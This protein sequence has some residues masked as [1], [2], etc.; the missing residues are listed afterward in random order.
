MNMFISRFSKIVLS[1]CI[2]LTMF[3]VKDLKAENEV[4]VEEATEAVAS[5]KLT[6]AMPI[7]ENKESTKT[8]ID[9]ELEDN[10]ST[11]NMSLITNP[12]LQIENGNITISMEGENK[13]YSQNGA[14]NII[15][16]G[17]IT[18][19]GTRNSSTITIMSGTHDLTINNLYVT[20]DSRVSVID[21]KAGSNLNLNISGVNNLSNEYIASGVNKAIVNISGQTH[22]LAHGNLVIDGDGTLTMTSG[23]FCTAI[24]GSQE[25]N[26]GNL[27][28]K[29]GTFNIDS[30]QGAASIGIGYK[31]TTNNGTITIEDGDFNIASNNLNAAIIGHSQSSVG[32]VD[33]NISG[34][35]FDLT[36]I[37][38]TGSA[39]IIGS[40]SGTRSVLKTGNINISGGNFVL[41][42]NGKGNLIGGTIGAISEINITDGTIIG[43]INTGY[44]S[45]LAA[46]GGGNYT[47]L[48]AKIHI[49]NADIT[50]NSTNTGPAIG[51]G[52][53]VSGACESVPSIE[54]VSGTIVTNAPS[55]SIA[56][57]TV[58]NTD[59]SRGVFT[60]TA[61]GSAN[62]Y[63]NGG[64]SIQNQTKVNEWS[65]FVHYDDQVVVYGNQ[66]INTDLTIDESKDFNMFQGSTL[67]LENNSTLT[68]ISDTTINGTLNINPGSKVIYNDRMS[69]SDHG[70]I[71]NNGEVEGTNAITSSSADKLV[72]TQL[73]DIILNNYFYYTG[74][75]I[76]I[77]E[78]IET[79]IQGLNEYIFNPMNYTRKIYK[80]S[81]YGYSEHISGVI[82]L[83]QYKLSYIPKVEGLTRIDKEFIVSDIDTYFE[84]A[85]LDYE[86]TYK[87]I[88]N[89]EIM[90]M[91]YDG[92]DLSKVDNATVALYLVDGENE[93]IIGEPQIINHGIANVWNI[94]TALN[95]IDKKYFTGSE[96]NIVARYINDDE[97][98][99]FDS[100]G[101]LIL[102]PKVIDSADI[103]AISSMRYTGLNL[104]PTIVINGVSADNYN[105]EYLNNINVGT[106]NVNITGKGYYIGS[107]SSTFDINAANIFYDGG[108]NLVNDNITY[109]DNLTFTI[110]PVIVTSYS[111]EAYD[112]HVVEVYLMQGENTRLIH[113]QDVLL[114]QENEITINTALD[115]VEEVFFNG[116]ETTLK[117]VYLGNDNLIRYEEADTI[118]L[119]PKTITEE[120]LGNL[121]Q[122]IYTGNPIEILIDVV[123]GK[124]LTNENY[125]LTYA[126]N[127]AV[128]NATINVIGKGYYQGT[129][130]KTFEIVKSNI[131]F[132]GNIVLDKASYIYGDV[133]NVSV[134]PILDSELRTIINPTIQFFIVNGD[135]EIAL[136]DKVEATI[137]IENNFTINSY[138]NL[139]PSS[140]Y[141]VENTYLK[142][143][144][145]GGSNLNNLEQTTLI[146][147]NKKELTIANVEDISDMKYTGTIIEPTIT[148][149]DN[150]QV[151]E[152]YT[153]TFTNNLNTGEALVTISLN[154]YYKGLINTTFNII[155]SDIEF[156]GNVQTNQDAYTYKDTIEVSITPTLKERVE[157]LNPKVNIF[158]EYNEEVVQVVTDE[159]VI[160]NSLNTYTIDTGL[161]TIPAHFFNN[162][163]VKLTVIYSGNENTTVY[164]EFKTITL[165][166]KDLT[167]AMVEDIMDQPFT[168]LEVRP[169]VTLIDVHTMDTTNYTVSYSNN[170]Y[171]GSAIATIDGQNYYQG[172]VSKNFNI[173]KGLLEF[174]DGITLNKNEFVIYEDLIAT[175]YPQSKYRTLGLS[176]NVY[177]QD[178]DNKNLILENVALNFNEDNTITI[179]T[180][181][182]PVE[183]Y[184]E[185]AI[186]LVISVFES[187]NTLAYETSTSF[188]LNKKSITTSMVSTLADEIYTGS[189]LT[190]IVELKDN[191]NVIL[192]SM[193][194]IGYTNNINVGTAVVNITANGY[195][196]D[197]IIANFN[198]NKGTVDFIDGITL[199]SSEYTYQDIIN[200]KLTI[201]LVEALRSIEKNNSLEVSLIDGDSEVL[202]ETLS[203]VNLNEEIELNIP[204]SDIPVDYYEKAGLTLVVKYYGNNNILAHQESV[205]IVLNKKVLTLDMVQLDSEYVYTGSEINPEITLFDNGVL[206]NDMYEAIY[207]NN[208]NVGNVPVI[209]NGLNYYKGIVNTSFDIIKADGEFNESWINKN[210]FTYGETIELTIQPQ[211][212]K[213]IELKELE[214]Y[215]STAS[216][217]YLL[218]G[219]ISLELDEVKNINID[220]KDIPVNFYEI[221]NVTLKVIYSG[222]ENV[223][224]IIEEQ[225]IVL[226]KKSL[227]NEM[228]NEIKD[229]S[230]NNTQH[231]PT[232]STNG[233]SSEDY[234]VEYKNNINVGKASVIFNGVKYYKG[235]VEVNFNINKIESTITVETDKAAITLKDELSINALVENDVNDYEKTYLLSYL[236]SGVSTNLDYITSKD[237]NVNFV[238]ESYSEKIPAHLYDMGEVELL[239]TRNGDD[240]INH[241]SDSIIVKLEKTD[242]SEA[243]FKGISDKYYTGQEIK[244]FVVGSNG[245]YD[246][247]LNQDFTTTYQNNVNIG[248]A[249][250]VING[251]GYF[252]GETLLNFEII[253]NKPVV[254][255]TPEADKDDESIE[256][257][258]II[259]EDNV[260]V[261]PE[262]N[263]DDTNINDNDSKEDNN[264]TNSDLEDEEDTKEDIVIETKEEGV[265]KVEIN[266]IEFDI[267]DLKFDENG[268]LIIDQNSLTNETNEVIVYYG[269]E[270]VKY[271]VIVDE[272]TA[273][274]FIKLENS[275]WLIYTLPLFL[276]LILLLI[277]FKKKKQEDKESLS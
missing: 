42:Q 204:T 158:M 10:D 259:D 103:Q 242:I 264:D 36:S 135:Q 79:K 260:L 104:E 14:A 34:G 157:I 150:E 122:Q 91:L 165:H 235:T 140:F 56:I 95:S 258:K 225:L 265:V 148:I 213:I 144:F 90:P 228:F 227:T 141:D 212:R 240:N 277:L 188:V 59:Q 173:T 180:K 263:N 151:I 88:L 253:E 5:N 11:Q 49:S 85:L 164:E 15:Y 43:N 138:D 108:I 63:I 139:I 124:T 35:D 172:S 93:I 47:N 271:T 209:I 80:M 4:I 77:N 218:V 252:K 72:Y 221:P 73:S 27:I 86:I 32:S 62:I 149:K 137:G 223:S 169:T 114:D 98:K 117:V 183:Y 66:T 58:C 160:L 233:I 40:G 167:V 134:T 87:D 241:I 168:N 51:G 161:N 24:G 175:I 64:G 118:R 22:T 7:E 234:S 71:I 189:A 133:I 78:T 65:M 187:D 21:V 215:L 195:Y 145:E 125:D 20:N 224:E 219:G 70:M 261:A 197:S 268:N 89:I 12:T 41:N 13:V 226:N 190:P 243:I 152:S 236:D 276:L 244:P 136:T 2:L 110:N 52:T 82:E 67:N 274:I 256:D 162:E 102:N 273:E 239:I 37:P 74:E 193:L 178:G 214:V 129:A 113:T 99:S 199:N 194:E 201:N 19:T 179:H 174:K 33:I 119:N 182:I 230:F 210:S 186:N 30:G 154:G 121:T 206:S 48:D 17:T 8:S 1:I 250:I 254:D 147:L 69:I 76:N 26:M 53:I 55:S 216:E 127:T 83:N 75:A 275:N 57:G 232:I 115:T 6:E 196:K 107:V 54:I 181:D 237:S 81:E 28:I 192:N 106:A 143:I 156:T 61:E 202:L 116:E 101:T 25:T 132:D 185:E 207:T 84:T 60:T 112:D 272:D 198:I 128:G 200:L 170:I 262:D 146:D 96:L 45:D 105:I 163:E 191:E 257:D 245:V 29:N 23:R 166:K 16:D 131:S 126:N 211:I 270:A 44:P 46:I 266:G 171:V 155:K 153:S 255:V 205:A 39:A 50:I 38:I 92:V 217:E 208:V 249:S 176:A 123:D 97:T 68:T 109:Q 203:N 222:N 267:S 142:V 159:E 269:D 9:N 251:L 111:A 238:L 177:V 247:S 100:N 130:S 184:T 229:V 220:T 248:M 31:A 94:D 3:S 246:L 231:K 18:L 120:M